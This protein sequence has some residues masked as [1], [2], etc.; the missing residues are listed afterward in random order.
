MSYAPSIDL[1]RWTPPGVPREFDADEIIEWA[2]ARFAGRRLAMTTAFGMEGVVLLD[3]LAARVPDIRV[4]YVDTGFLFED[5]H[6]L[7][8]RLDERFPSARFQRVVPRLTPGAQAEHFGDGLWH[9]DPDLCCRIRKVE[10]MHR[11]MADVD[12]W[13]A[14][15]RREQTE[16]RRNLRIVGWD[17][18]YQTI[19][20]CPLASWS[21]QRIFDYVTTNGLPYNTMHDR[22]YPSVG[23]T[24]CTQPV[25]GARPWEYS[26]AG[27][28]A[29][30]PKTECGLHDSIVE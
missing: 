24:H 23:C 16:T 11:A 27:R 14:A 12:V 10:P 29:G 20:V 17:W 15:L 3:K 4:I 8:R 9:S 26:R 1:S 18:R 30:T 22:A 19:R 2:I 25:P 13:F 6:D 5:T 28:W 7:R 21:R